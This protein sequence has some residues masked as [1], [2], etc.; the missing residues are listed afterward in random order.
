MF[1]QIQPHD[2]CLK[3]GV[4]VLESNGTI[5]K[6]L[7]GLLQQDLVITSANN[8]VRVQFYS[9]SVIQ[10]AGFLASWVAI[11]KDKDVT[12]EVEDVENAGES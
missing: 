1:L 4:I 7:C 6:H 8:S 9:D 10:A 12:T 11:P 5:L 2:Y 3:D